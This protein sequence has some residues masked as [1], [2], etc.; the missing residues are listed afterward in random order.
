MDRHD[1]ELKSDLS[2]PTASP[3]LLL[4][5]A[6]TKDS[7]HKFPNYSKIPKKKTHHVPH[8]KDRNGRRKVY[9]HLP[10]H[11]QLEITHHH[12]KFHRMKHHKSNRTIHKVHLL[13]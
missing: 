7:T 12:D 9:P 6:I 3:L 13:P 10:L 11:S 2:V 4:K 8:K 5:G 1:I